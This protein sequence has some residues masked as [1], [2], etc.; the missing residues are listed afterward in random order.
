MPSS[1]DDIGG[2]GSPSAWRVWIEI[3]I[4]AIRCLIAGVTLRMEG[5]DRNNCIQYLCQFPGVTLRMEGV[6]RN[7]E[8]GNKKNARKLSPS[9]WRV[10]IEITTASAHSRAKRVTL[11]M[12]GVDRNHQYYIYNG[13]RKVSPSAWRVWIEI[14]RLCGTASMRTRHP[15]HGGCG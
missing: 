14:L 13:R 2:F 4:R 5:V 12:E 10:W 8:N 3:I 6:D 7:F 9:A 1:A 11:R 15:P